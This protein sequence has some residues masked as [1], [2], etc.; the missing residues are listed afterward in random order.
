KIETAKANG[1]WSALD[2]VENEIIPNELQVAFNNNQQAFENYKNFAPSYR[3]SYLHWL[4][5]A[6]REETRLKRIEKIIKL[7]INNKKTP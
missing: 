7:C 2:D 5:Q 1:S 3:K 6:K 4:K